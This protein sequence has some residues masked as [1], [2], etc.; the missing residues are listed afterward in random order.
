MH[1]FLMTRQ[2]LQLTNPVIIHK[3]RHY[4]AILILIINEELGL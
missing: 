4:F 3:P 1:F 2:P